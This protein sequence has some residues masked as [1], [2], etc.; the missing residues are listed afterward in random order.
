MTLPPTADDGSFTISRGLLCAYEAT[1]YLV[2]THR[3]IV[4]LRVGKEL[5]LEAS[6]IAF[7]NC[8]AVITAFNPFSRA[9]AEDE[10][11]QRQIALAKAVEV[12]GRSWLPAQGVDPLGRWPAE[13]SLAVLDPTDHELDYWMELFGQNA[14]VV[15]AK[16]FTTSLRLHPRSITS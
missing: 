1:D 6:L 10:N 12:A 5:D 11:Q 8:F 7:I 13:P 14:V 2:E 3:G 16:G 4:T 15:A 9:V